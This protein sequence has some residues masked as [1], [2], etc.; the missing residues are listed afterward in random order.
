VCAF[1]VFRV[2]DAPPRGGWLVGVSNVGGGTRG[3]GGG[4]AVID[5]KAVATGWVVATCKKKTANRYLLF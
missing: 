5:Y 2:G 1:R 4:G 3:G